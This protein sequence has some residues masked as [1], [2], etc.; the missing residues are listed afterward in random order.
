MTWG[1]GT[2]LRRRFF[3]FMPGEEKLARRFFWYFLLLAAAQTIIK[4]LR[5]THFLFR[6]GVGALPIAYLI[7]AVAT[8]LVVLLHSKVQFKASLRTVITVSLLLFAATGFV[9]S[10]VIATDLGKKS[11]FIAY[12]Y[13][14][15]ASV[16][17]VALMTHFWMTINETY[18]PRQAKRLV[19]YIGTG[20]ILGSMLG[21][22]LVIVLSGP[23]LP[24]WLMS[25]ACA[26][27]V[28]CVPVVAAISRLSQKER[29]AGGPP[30]AGTDAPDGRKPGFWD[31]LQA[32]R[33]SRFLLLI[34]GIV[35]IG[36]IVSTCIEFQYLCAAFSHFRSSPAS[37]QAF[38]GF[39]DP[40]LTLVALFLNLAL[41]GSLLKKLDM[42]QA[43]LFTPAVL[44]GGSA[45]VLCL[46]FGLLSGIIIR[47]GDEGMGYAVNQSVREILYIPIG[48]RLR[49]KVKPFI[50]MFISQ[51]ARVAGAVILLIFALLSN[52]R[53]VGFTPGFD[54]GMAKKLSWA[55]IALLVPWALLGRKA[56][57]EYPEAIR[58]TIKP[59]W[60]RAEERVRDRLDVGHAK[61]VFDTIDSRNH[62]SVLYALHIFDLLE[63]D[64]LTPEIK[65][66]IAEKSEEIEATLLA[67]RFGAG[68]VAQLEE[69]FDEL[70]P[71]D[72][73]T[74]IP[75]I[76]TSD[77]Y[78]RVMVEYF[79]KV[80]E[81]GPAAEIQKMELAK[82]IGLQPA[83]TPMAARLGRL[84]M[85]GSPR[86][87]CQALKSAARLKRRDHL[88]AIIRK[89][90]NYLTLEDAIDAL[91]QYGDAA[92]PALVENL[93]DRSEG[94]ILRRAAAEALARIGT[95]AAAK[96]LAHE[97]EHGRGDI[98]EAVIDALDR[99][100]SGPSEVHVSAA[101]AKRKTLAFVREYCR[102]YL[103]LQGEEPDGTKEDP[104]RRPEA[105]L[106]TYLADIFKLLGLYYPHKHV[107]T[108]Y[109]NIKAGSRHSVAH[110]VE[111]LDNALKKDMRDA[112]L[113]LVEDLEPAE[114]TERFE[115]LLKTLPAD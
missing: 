64:K 106:E 34:A 66:L 63:R 68:G 29:E 32:I 42:T 75:L 51:V 35:G 100:H 99:V 4:T 61:L 56:G 69:I 33:T 55:V 20:G 96:A 44:L 87:S 92:V 19:G 47:G 45:L 23:D 109:Q 101:A 70:R 9:L 77:E 15:W 3:H 76:T 83:G 14:V 79:D 30:P 114:R 31:S 43:L 94:V 49:H 13:W 85:D 41:S 72:I 107:R 60:D 80:I 36:V 71:Q 91:Q 74:E 81:E 103:E 54:V 93:K 40:A 10:F 65:A 38:F 57:R 48:S 108:A 82:A 6:E 22:V 105:S 27:L 21:G 12:I 25:M 115:A 39:F 59:L 17:T 86:V 53:I 104:R 52:D 7:A 1:H 8:G 112:L 111:W 62:S 98:D 50:D 5:T 11:T 97:L 113:P 46:P 18:D 88:P 58:R 73:L 90:D 84:I 110:A 26:M 37:L 24:P 78:Q 28:A 16:L 95:R 89:L 102:I 67:D 2:S